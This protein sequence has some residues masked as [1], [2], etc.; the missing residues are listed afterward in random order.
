MKR[1]FLSVLIILLFATSSQSGE[2]VCK[3]INA[4]A[5]LGSGQANCLI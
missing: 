5:N 2:S 1:T 3:A 4:K